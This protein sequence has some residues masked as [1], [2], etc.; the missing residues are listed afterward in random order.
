MGVFAV[1][2]TSLCNGSIVSHIARKLPISLLGR[3]SKT[4][5]KAF[6][7]ILSMALHMRSLIHWLRSSYACIP[8][9]S[10]HFFLPVVH[11]NSY[12]QFHTAIVCFGT[13]Y[14]DRAFGHIFNSLHSQLI[15]TTR[16]SAEPY[17]HQQGHF[18]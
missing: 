6:Q 15:T 4:V 1:Q 2:I 9:L 14:F 7:P 10:A 18:R 8:T 5:S 3:L 16:S 13:K 11:A 12:T 17:R